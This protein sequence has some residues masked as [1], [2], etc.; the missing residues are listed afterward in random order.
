MI[1]NIPPLE[2]PEHILSGIAKRS[3]EQSVTVNAI[4]VEICTKA[5]IEAALQKPLAHAETLP[6]K[7]A[8]LARA[9]QQPHS[10][11][12][13]A[14]PSTDKRALKYALKY[15]DPR[16]INKRAFEAVLIIA[17]NVTAGSKEFKIPDNVA[18]RLCE[19]HN[20]NQ[21]G[22]PLL[23]R[24]FKAGRI[25]LLT[26]C[27][28]GIAIIRPKKDVCD[29]KRCTCSKSCSAVMNSPHQGKGRVTLTC[30]NED[31]KKTFSR[32]QWRTKGKKRQYC[33]NKCHH[34]DMLGIHM[35]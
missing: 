20:I 25:L 22:I 35:H 10:P 9:V 7:G 18:R 15:G 17:G 1:I 27:R 31:C 28:C 11:I 21:A 30:A 2:L 26:C 4:V 16:L 32:E 8:L 24:H 34:R 6:D 13:S 19:I 12:T 29:P 5:L 23:H 33:S 14:L 3:L